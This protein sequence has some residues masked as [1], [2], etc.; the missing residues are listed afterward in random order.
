MTSEQAQ[1]QFEIIK[2]EINQLQTNLIEINKKIKSSNIEINQSDINHEEDND[3]L[4]RNKYLQLK[5]KQQVYKNDLEMIESY[6]NSKKT[7]DSEEQEENYFIEKQQQYNDAMNEIKNWFSNLKEVQKYKEILKVRAEDSET[8]LET[9]LYEMGITLRQYEKLLKIYYSQETYEKISNDFGYKEISENELETLVENNKISYDEKVLYQLYNNMIASND[10][11]RKIR[12]ELG[13]MQ[14][15][16]KLLAQID[17]YPNSV[18]FKLK[19]LYETIHEQIEIID[20]NN[21]TYDLLYDI[22]RKNN[23]EI[24]EHKKYNNTSRETFVDILFEIKE[25]KTSKISKLI[26][27]TNKIT[28][29][30]FKEKIARK[31]KRKCSEEEKKSLKEK[32]K[33]FFEKKFGAET[34]RKKAKNAQKKQELIEKIKDEKEKI[35]HKQINTILVENDCEK[36]QSY[37]KKTMNNIYEQDIYYVQKSLNKD[38][39]D[40]EYMNM[41]IKD[42]SNLLKKILLFK[43][44]EEYFNKLKKD[45]TDIFNEQSS[46]MFI[47]RIN[48]YFENEKQNVN[49]PEQ[50][51]IVLDIIKSLRKAEKN[52]ILT[53]NDILKNHNKNETLEDKIVYDLL[54][55]Y[56]NISD[57][58]PLTTLSDRYEFVFILGKQPNEK[59]YKLETHIKIE[60]NFELNDNEKTRKK[61][62]PSEKLKK[63]HFLSEDATNMFKKINQA[64]FEKYGY[65]GEIIKEK[66]YDASLILKESNINSING[67]ELK[68]IDNNRDVMLSSFLKFHEKIQEIKYLEKVMTESENIADFLNKLNI[69]ENKNLKDIYF[70]SSNELKKYT[71][72]EKKFSSMYANMDEDAKKIIE[73]YSCR[74][75]LSQK[76]KNEWLGY[77]EILYYL[78]KIYINLKSIINDNNDHVITTKDIKNVVDYVVYNRPPQDNEVLYMITGTS[79]EEINNIDEDH[80]DN[81]NYKTS[82]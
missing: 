59:I 72:I 58:E 40:E 39:S 28:Y 43:N 63:Y 47:K 19:K 6:I 31:V 42:L 69:D 80:L 77:K 70:S 13:D 17:N 18:A 29:D 16:R 79:K 66:L 30:F 25:L 56:E 71:D 23:K 37:I 33:E 52:V 22:E 36:V 38:I 14:K 78:D 8:D 48:N 76:G 10:N 50:K 7:M 21:K 11:F 73:K 53:I 4:Y 45:L 2:N 54:E 34:K 82:I 46:N 75:Y 3:E 55:N 5:E 44:N 67:T 26:G 9:V 64:R 15:N 68:K 74:E 51:K 32:T 49:N 65:I 24:K 41:D 20:E 81:S 61:I 1:Q 62:M 60:K 35:I 12:T 57:N 27:K